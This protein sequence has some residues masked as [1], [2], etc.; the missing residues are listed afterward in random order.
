M[1]NHTKIFWYAAYQHISISW[2]WKKSLH[3]QQ[4]QISH[5]SK[6]WYYLYFSHSCA[7]IKIGSYDLLPLEKTF[8]LH[9]VIILINLAFDKEQNCCKY[10]IKSSYQL[11]K[12]GNK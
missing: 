9:N 2:P 4:D 11:P 3:F 6:N 10:N 12:K 5:R 8:T 7:S 1:K